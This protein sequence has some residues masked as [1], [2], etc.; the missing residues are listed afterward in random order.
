M[1]RGS[2]YPRA[3]GADE[4]GAVPAGGVPAWRYHGASGTVGNAVGTMRNFNQENGVI[5]FKGSHVLKGKARATM[6]TVETKFKQEELRVRR[7][8]CFVRG[9]H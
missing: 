5:H 2:A 1:R 4:G 3:E 8:A 6:S 9:G 7:K